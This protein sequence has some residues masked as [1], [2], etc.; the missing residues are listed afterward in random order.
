LASSTA[1]AGFA[2][3]ASRRT[4]GHPHN[5]RSAKRALQIN[6]HNIGYLL[7]KSITRHSKLN[8]NNRPNLVEAFFTKREMP[9]DA[10]AQPFRAPNRRKTL[11]VFVAPSWP[12]RM[13]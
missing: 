5:E 4:V 6:Q 13:Q 2:A 8:I 7:F 1:P 11:Q 10:P 9:A 12:I 3:R